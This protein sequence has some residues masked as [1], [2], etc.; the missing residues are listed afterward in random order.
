MKKQRK[1]TR[2]VLEEERSIAALLKRVGYTGTKSKDCKNEIP[3]YRTDNYTHTSNKIPAAGPRKYQ[4]KYTGDQL[5]GIAETHK[6][7]AVPIRKDNK[8][9]AVDAANMRRN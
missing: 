1:K 6:S 5:M 4:P 3:S 7:N 9:A 8:Q 2:A